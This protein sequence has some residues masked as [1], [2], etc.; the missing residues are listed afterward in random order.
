MFRTIA[1]RC[2]LFLALIFLTAPVSRI[3]AQSTTPTSGAVTGGDPQ[4]TGEPPPPKPQTSAALPIAIVT[5]LVAL[6]LA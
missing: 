5:T 1:Q 3:H 2:A 4:P 6:G